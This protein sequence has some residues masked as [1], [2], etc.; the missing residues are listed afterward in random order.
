MNA[1]VNL[2]GNGNAISELRESG[3]GDADFR[4]KKER[5]HYYPA[6]DNFEGR[7]L[8]KEVYYREDN[9]NYLGLHSNL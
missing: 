5:I 9:G 4:V 2:H 7:P 3:Y 1:V 8:N 6:S